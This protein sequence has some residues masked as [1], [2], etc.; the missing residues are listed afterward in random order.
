MS[1]GSVFHRAYRYRLRSNRKAEAVLRRWAGCSRKV[2]N[3]ALAEQQARRERGEKYAGLVGMCQWVTAWRKAPETAYLAEVPGHVLQNVVCALDGAV[4]RL[5]RHQRAVARKLEAA[6]VAA[7]IPGGKPFP[8]G[9]RLRPSNRLRKARARVAKIH[10]GIAR[11]RADFLHKLSTQIAR[12]H[13]LVCLEALRVRSM[14]ASAAATQEAPGKRVRQKAGLNRAI[15][16]Q[17]SGLVAV[18]GAARLQARM[19]RRRARTRPSRL[20]LAALSRLRSHPCG[21]PQGRSFSVSVLWL[22]RPCEPQC[23]EEHTGRGTR[24]SGRRRPSARGGTGAV[25]PPSEARTHRGATPC[26]LAQ[27]ESPPFT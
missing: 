4:Q 14:S 7:G 3:L 6:K 1:E 15:L 11:Q 24:G 10:Q 21:Q 9:F 26:G 23:R 17:G 22:H 13:A 18:Q 27:Q 8:K 20:Y 12:E 2:W 19:A 16:D 5:R 25:R